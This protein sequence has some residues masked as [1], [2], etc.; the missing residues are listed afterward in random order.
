MNTNK[1]KVI[2]SLIPDDT[3]WC[4]QDSPHMT[5]VYVGEIEEVKNYELG[6]LFKEVSE[7]AKVTRPVLAKVDGHDIFGEEE[8]VDVLVISK[9]KPIMDLRKSLSH[10]DKSIFPTFEPHA[11]IGPVG[12]FTGKIPMYLLFGKIEIMMGDTVLPFWLTKQ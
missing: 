9:E 3:S 2:V 6:N 12:S 7:L 10:W 5:L 4:L 8:K 1:T 11:T